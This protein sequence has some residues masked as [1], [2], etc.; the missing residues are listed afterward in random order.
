M[1]DSVSGN[2]TIYED[3]K[4]LDRYNIKAAVH[5]AAVTGG[6]S[7]TMAFSINVLGTR[8]LLRYLADKG[9]R[10]IVCASSIAAVG[11][12]STEFR[13][14]ALPIP[15]DHPCLDRDGYGVSKFLMEEIT[16]YIQRSVPELDI[17]NLR[18][19]SVIP[20]TTPRPLV[21]AGSLGK[22]ALGTI[23][24]MTLRDAVTAFTLAVESQLRPGVRTLNAAGPR[25]WVSQPVSEVLKSWYGKDVDTSHFDQR[26]HA[27]AGVFDVSKIREQLG[28]VALDGPDVVHRSHYPGPLDI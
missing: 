13:P 7:E 19:S 22:W 2:F 12:Q 25:A 4:Q 15:D 9:C 16:H 18:L 20:D 21:A 17:I 11:F 8:T 6:A 28:F 14:L 1:S 26:E 3:L 10:K 27:W 5:L 23:T 24:I